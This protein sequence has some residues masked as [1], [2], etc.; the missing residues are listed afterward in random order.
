MKEQFKNCNDKFDD[1]M[2]DLQNQIDSLF[3]NIT[4]DKEDIDDLKEN[5]ANLEVSITDI[6]SEVDDVDQRVIENTQNIDSN[7]E[8]IGDIQTNLNTLENKPR[9]AAEIS[10]LTSGSYLPLED[11]TDFTEKIDIGNIFDPKTGIVTIKDEGTYVFQISAHKDNAYG[12]VGFIRVYKNHGLTRRINEG[13]GGHDLMLNMVFTFDLQKGD[14]VKLSNV[15]EE[16]IYVDS[17][18][19]FTFIGYK[20]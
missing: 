15:Y 5:V 18:F 12:Q 2:L 6:E 16:S 4:A 8:N 11:I 9:F 19:P 1:G 14:E 20:I 7:V 10:S 17:Y 13:D 3:R